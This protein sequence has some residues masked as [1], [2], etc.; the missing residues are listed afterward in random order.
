M[1]LYS[2]IADAE[3]STYTYKPL[4][5]ITSETDENGVTTYYEYDNLNRLEYIKDHELNILN[6]N[7][8][9]YFIQD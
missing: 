8:Y 1:P 5:G 2:D 6:K 9:S 3:V 7:E 4:V